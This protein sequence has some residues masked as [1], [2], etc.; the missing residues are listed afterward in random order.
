MD[1]ELVPCENKIEVAEDCQVV[2]VYDGDKTT[3]QYEEFYTI[4]TIGGNGYRIRPDKYEEVKLLLNDPSVRFIEVGKKKN[5]VAVHQITE[6]KKE[7]R[8][9][10]AG[11]KW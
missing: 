3:M 1:K 7:T 6:V 8:I 11:G 9:L 5:L 4:Y 2:T 10:R